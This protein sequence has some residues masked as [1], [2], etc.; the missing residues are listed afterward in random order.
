[1]DCE[2]K[3]RKR[4][5]FKNMDT[6]KGTKERDIQTKVIYININVIVNNRLLGMNINY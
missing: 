3:Y 2:F 5:T 1:M 6:Y 4:L